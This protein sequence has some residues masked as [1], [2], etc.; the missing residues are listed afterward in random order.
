M[1]KFRNKMGIYN[2]NGDVLHIRFYIQES[3]NSALVMVLVIV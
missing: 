1:D 3:V 2:L